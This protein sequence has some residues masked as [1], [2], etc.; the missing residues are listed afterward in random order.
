MIRVLVVDDH[1]IVRKGLKQILAE[2]PDMEVSVEATNAAELMQQVQERQWDVIVL[3]ITL[4]DRSGIDVLKDVKAIYPEL[5][6]LILS[7]HPEDQYA[8][9]ALKAGA[10]GYIT[11]KSAG[12]ELVTAIRKAVGGG[13]YVSPSLAEKLAME[14]GADHRKLPHERLS[15]REFQ[16]MCL[17][18]SGKR[19]GE[20][21]YEI[22]L[23]VKT[24]STYRG[25]I[26]GKMSMK[27][28]AELTIY[29]MEHDLLEK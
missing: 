20:I 5:P 27:S 26:L 19:L 13:R 1:P 12:E 7:M 28:N 2:E 17:L 29:C 24:I 3:D 23:S 4:P 21:A 15:D 10:A 18:A 6:V 22:S 16:V 14:V 9:R 11:K 8:T 25:R